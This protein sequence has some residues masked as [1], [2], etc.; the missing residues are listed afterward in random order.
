MR[1][2]TGDFKEDSIVQFFSSNPNSQK[3]R[4]MAKKEFLNGIL[5]KGDNIDYSI[6]EETGYCTLDI[7]FNGNVK[8]LEVEINRLSANRA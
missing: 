6:D 3:S 1:H 5:C 7:T 2:G 8:N 4:W